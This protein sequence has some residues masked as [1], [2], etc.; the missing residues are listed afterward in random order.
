METIKFSFQTVLMTMLAF[1]CVAMCMMCTSC[2]SGDDD[3]P[4]PTPAPVENVA[5]HRIQISMFA[6][7]DNLW[8]ID[9]WLWG[10]APMSAKS[11]PELKLDLP[12]T[13]GFAKYLPDNDRDSYDRNLPTVRIIGA[14]NCRVT[15]VQ[16]CEYLSVNIK[17]M[18]YDYNGDYPS[19]TLWIRL[20]G[21]VD[22]VLT[23]KI[24]KEITADYNI[25]IVFS[26]V[27]RDGDVCEIT[28]RFDMSTG[29]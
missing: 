10:C 24:E 5:K 11:N 19:E 26:S 14:T 28:D 17:A 25:H 7:R 27:P 22:G 13:S 18:S 15:S 2:S 16:D 21:Y 8:G 6:T 1:L 9:G 29:K 3:L 12:D 4:E 20:E 23:N